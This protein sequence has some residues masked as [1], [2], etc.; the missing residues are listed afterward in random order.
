[1]TVVEFRGA[2]LG[3]SFKKDEFYEKYGKP[4]GVRRPACRKVL[5]DFCT[6]VLFAVGRQS[7]QTHRP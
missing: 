3:K 2:V 6:L 1:M 7:V 5:I 4:G